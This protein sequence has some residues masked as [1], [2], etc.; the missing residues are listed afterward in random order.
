MRPLRVFYGTSK[1]WDRWN[2][3]Y[4]SLFIPLS[5]QHLA[6]AV[7]KNPFIY[8]LIYC[9][10]HA[11]SPSGTRLTA[12]TSRSL[13]QVS[14]SDKKT[15]IRSSKDGW[16]CMVD[17]GWGV[18]GSGVFF[19]F[20]NGYFGGL[21]EREGV[22][23]VFMWRVFVGVGYGDGDDGYILFYKGRGVRFL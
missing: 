3:L 16:M 17:V 12:G 11:S 7:E 23:G 22:Y 18:S 9:P 2:L 4:F 21:R 10:F 8:R 14:S 6:A 1:R 19:N 13:V 5:L 15:A 20:E